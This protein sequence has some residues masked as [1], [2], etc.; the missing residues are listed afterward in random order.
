MISDHVLQRAT[1]PPELSFILIHRHVL[2]GCPNLEETR[3]GADANGI[4]QA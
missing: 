3:I 2:V 4:G 1:S